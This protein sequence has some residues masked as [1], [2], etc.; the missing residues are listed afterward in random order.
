MSSGKD[1]KSSSGGRQAPEDRKH[2]FAIW[3]IFAAFLG[4]ML[5]QSLWLRYTQV[6]TIP[7]SQFEQLL[8]DGKIA[9]VRSAQDR[10]Q[11]TL[12]E[13]LPNGERN[14]TRSASIRSSPT[15]SRAHGVVVKGAPSGSVICR[16]SCRGSCRHSSST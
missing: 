9:E 16:P 11:G 14:S 8:Q 4:L 2:Q 15:S 5:F 12:K 1:A 10:I 3:Y 6:E 7:Y 13:P